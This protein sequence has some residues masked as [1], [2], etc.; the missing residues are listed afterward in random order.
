MCSCF[1]KLAARR[2]EL[3]VI[4][5]VAACLQQATVP[6]A[7]PQSVPEWL[8]PLVTILPGQLLAM[9]LAHA[10]GIDPDTPRGLSKITRTR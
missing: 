2:A 4:G 6:L 3:I 1:R 8:S 7:L 5:D 10:R 9:Y